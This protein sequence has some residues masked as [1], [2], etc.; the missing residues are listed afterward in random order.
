M[1]KLFFLP[2]S[3]GSGLVAGVLSKKLFGAVWGVIDDEEPPQA[4]HR[5]VDY[6]K[7]VAAMAIQG[8]IFALVRGM[9][10]HGAR[11]GYARVTGSWPGEE[12]PEEKD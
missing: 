8:A 10:D 5:E 11:Q 7:L 6:V 2:V 9:V 3:M 1:G 12:E 4:E